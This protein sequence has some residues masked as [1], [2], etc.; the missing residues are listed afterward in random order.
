MNNE[1]YN[2][3]KKLI[4]KASD[5]SKSYSSD[6]NRI[7][8]VDN[9][10]IDLFS[11][12]FVSLT[13]PSGCGKTTILMIIGCL[14]KPDHG[15]VEIDGLDIYSMNS[16]RIAEQRSKKI[17]FIYQDFKLIPYLTIKENI[18]CS[19]LINDVVNLEDKAN[20]LILRL[21]LIHRVNHR[22]EQLSAGEKQ[23]TAIARALLME[24]KLIIADEPTGNLDKKNSSLV[25]EALKHY[26]DEGACVIMVSHDEDVKKSS[27]RH[28]QM[29]PI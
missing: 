23:R 2:T 1:R 27:D 14:L 20:D 19:S 11:S 7:K 29:D 17:G 15:T 24:P 10:N 9:Y 21:G 4:L 13:G 26:S 6:K 3:D 25:I 16:S 12:E 8:V 18:L 22:P 5:I 28:I